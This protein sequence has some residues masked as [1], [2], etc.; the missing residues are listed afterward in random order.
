MNDTTQPTPMPGLEPATPISGGAGAACAT[1]TGTVQ[2]WGDPAFGARGN[3]SATHVSSGVNRP[4]GL[5]DGVT[6]LSM[7]GCGGCAVAQKT[8]YCWGGRWHGALGDN[9]MTDYSYTPVDVI[10]P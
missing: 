9:D 5:P 6:A 10:R 2:C 8:T 7:G 1:T 4:Y 3:G